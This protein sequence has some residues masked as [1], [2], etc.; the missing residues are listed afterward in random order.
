MINTLP[1]TQRKLVRFSEKV[2]VRPHLHLNN[3]TDEEIDNVWYSREEYRAIRNHTKSMVHLMTDAL[4]RNVTLGPDLCTRGL[5]SNL[6]SDENIYV[7]KNTVLGVQ[8]H[9]LTTMGNPDPVTL[10]QVSLNHS[11]ESLSTALRQAAHDAIEAGS[12]STKRKLNPT[13]P[14]SC[15]SPNRKVLRIRT[16]RAF[17]VTS[18][19]R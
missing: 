19:T 16:Y 3:M 14:P 12:M 9:Q 7:H 1:M 10:R 4:E 11:I 2:R 13:L 17:R 15:S 18:V 8:Q 5:E 6:Q